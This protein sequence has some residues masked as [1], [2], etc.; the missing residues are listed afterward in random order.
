MALNWG[1]L[2]KGAIGA[3][4]G[5]VGMASVGASLL[6]GLFGKKKPQE[7]NPIP[8]DVRALRQGTADYLGQNRGALQQT[9]AQAGPVNYGGTQTVGQQQLAPTSQSTYNP[10]QYSQA[11]TAQS[12]GTGPVAFGGLSQ[13]GNGQTPSFIN[14][15]ANQ[16]VQSGLQNIDPSVRSRLLAGGGTVG[17]QGVAGIAPTQSIDQLG[18]GFAS[19]FMQ[20]YNPMF[21]QQRQQAIAQAKEGAGNLTGSGFANALGNATAQTLGQQQAQL[22][23]LAQFGIGQETG[24]QQTMAGLENQRNL[25]D[26]GNSLQAGIANANNQL[27]GASQYGALGQQQND[28]FLR[29]MGLNQQGLGMALQG[30]QANLGRQQDTSNRSGEL[31]LYGGI[32]NR[33]ITSGEQQFNTGQ[34]NNMNQFN[35]GQANNMGQF[36]AGQQLQ[37]SQFNAGQQNNMNQFGANLNQSLGL[38]NRGFDS[39]EGQFGANLGQQNN[40]F[41]VGQQNDMNNAN[42]NRIAQLTGQMTTT[43]VGTPQ[44]YQQPNF[45]QSLGAGLGNMLPSLINRGGTQSMPSSPPN[46]NVGNIMSGVNVPNVGAPSWVDSQAAARDPQ[47]FAKWTQGYNAQQ[48]SGSPGYNFAPGVANM[49]SA[50]G[51]TTGFL[52]GSMGSLGGVNGRPQSSFLNSLPTMSVL[53]N[54]ANAPRPYMV[55]GR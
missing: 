45:L 47:G 7:T 18:T 23:S 38:A 50:Q 9:A 15:L 49:Q 44:Q 37:N 1:G 13:V 4:G 35:T 17:A 11:Q 6:G 3:L 48:T 10:A 21:E 12:A 26:A 31:G 14:S 19:Q 5:P 34:Q 28:S 41:N 24:R 53:G 27:Q 32:Q 39:Q 8:Q 20:N 40:Q 42:A 22:A 33:Q 29:A 46:V 54:P 16:N 55:Q 36:N 51:Q 2:A 43:G 52:G 25:A 30:E